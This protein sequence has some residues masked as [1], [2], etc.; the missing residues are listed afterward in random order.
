MDVRVGKSERG[1]NGSG[2]MERRNRRE[3]QRIQKMSSFFLFPFIPEQL[4]P[5]S[6]S[7]DKERQESVLGRVRSLSS[8]PKGSKKVCC[9]AKGDAV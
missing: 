2:Q 1:Q 9:Q 4:C 6:R 7:W 8:E 3:H 5:R